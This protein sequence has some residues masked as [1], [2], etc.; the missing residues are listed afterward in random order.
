VQLDIVELLIGNMQFSLR[1]A[2]YVIVFMTLVRSVL[3]LTGSKRAFRTW[4]RNTKLSILSILLAP[5]IF[6]NTGIRYAVCSVLGV[7]VEGVGLGTTYAEVNAFI[8]VDR[9]PSVAALLIA[10]FLSSLA[11]VFV[12]F[13]FLF[14]PIV[15]AMDWSFVLASWYLCAAVLV[16]SCIRSGDLSLLRASLKRQG[17]RGAIELIAVITGLAL[18]YTQIVGVYL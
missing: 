10:L 12:G 5:G 8:H 13:F 3:L 9:P 15:I 7:Q 6:I 2:P 18:F 1:I 14:A 4:T 17:H 16:N 11:S